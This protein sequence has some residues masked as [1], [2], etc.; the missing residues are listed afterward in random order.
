MYYIGIDNGKN[1]AMA[2]VEFA[3]N[4]KIVDVLKYDSENPLVF[5]NALK[6]YDPAKCFAYLEEPIVVYG[7]AHQTAPYETIGRHKMTLE[8][9]GISYTVG[10]PRMTS[11]ENW[12]N[13][14]GLKGKADQASKAAA[15]ELSM[16]NK[17]LK[18]VVA[19]AEKSGYSKAQLKSSKKEYMPEKLKIYK[20]EYK[21]IQKEIGKNKSE[22]KARVKQVSLDYCLE[23]YPD[24]LKFLEKSRSSKLDDDIAEALLLAECG[25]IVYG[26]KK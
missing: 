15:E 2:I 9:L 13:I 17:K 6:E 23:I 1:G 8:I 22:R 16:L 3:K 14:L 7:L 12:K 5:Y 24:S 25:R 20:E 4:R 11:K 26:L 21:T 18:T 10:S 19:E